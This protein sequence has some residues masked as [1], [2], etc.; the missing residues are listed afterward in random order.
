MGA[1]FKEYPEIFFVPDVE[2]PPEQFFMDIPAPNPT[3]LLFK[4]FMQSFH[5]TGSLAVRYPQ[6]KFRPGSSEEIADC[7]SSRNKGTAGAVI[8]VASASMETKTAPE[9]GIILKMQNIHQGCQGCLGTIVGFPFVL[10]PE[11]TRSIH[12]FRFRTSSN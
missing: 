6:I 12:A 3:E 9:K 7:D 11:L 1:H 2:F 8:T 4:I 5:Q 10:F